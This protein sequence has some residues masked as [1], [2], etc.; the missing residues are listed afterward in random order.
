MIINRSVINNPHTYETTTT[1]TGETATVPTATI[2]L[3]IRLL[4]QL[5]PVIVNPTDA[6]IIRYSLAIAQSFEQI[7]LMS[8]LLLQFSVYKQ[9]SSSDAIVYYELLMISLMNLSRLH[10]LHDLLSQGISLTK[11]ATSSIAAQ[12]SEEEKNDSDEIIKSNSISCLI[13]R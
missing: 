12:M 4:E 3:L 11:L 13:N 9:H 10:E 8:Y 7:Y 6:T 5:F 1:T 2:P